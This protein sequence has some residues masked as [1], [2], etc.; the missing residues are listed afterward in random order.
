MPVGVWF[1]STRLL[2]KYTL[3]DS[4]YKAGH[5]IIQQALSRKQKIYLAALFSMMFLFMELLWRMMFEFLI[6]YMQMRDALIA[7]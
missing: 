3:M 7:L 6:A 2:K 5:S 4:A 1:L